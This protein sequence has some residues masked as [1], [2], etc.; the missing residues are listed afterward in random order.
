MEIRNKIIKI[1][2]PKICGRL[3]CKDCRQELYPSCDFKQCVDQILALFK[4]LKYGN[5]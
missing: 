5:K 2:Y 3:R 4:G 1:L